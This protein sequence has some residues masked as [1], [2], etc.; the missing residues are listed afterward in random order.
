MNIG[1]TNLRGLD[2][3]GPQFP[4]KET[5]FRLCRCVKLGYVEEAVGANC[6]DAEFLMALET[7]Y[8]GNQTFLS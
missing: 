7:L 3:K 1:Y 8:F 4:K 6:I 5:F 2:E